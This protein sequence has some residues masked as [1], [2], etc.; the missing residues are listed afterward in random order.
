MQIAFYNA[1]GAAM[2]LLG[3]IRKLMFASGIGALIYLLSDFQNYFM[4]GNK[5][6][7]L[8]A[9]ED[10]FTE[11]LSIADKNIAIFMLKWEIMKQKM[12]P[13]GVDLSFMQGQQ[14]TEFRQD[15]IVR[16]SAKMEVYKGILNFFSSIGNPFDS[17]VQPQPKKKSDAIQKD[18][19]G[20]GVRKIDMTI[21]FNDLPQDVKNS[22]TNMDFLNFGVG[23]GKTF[24]VGGLGQNNH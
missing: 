21:N 8:G 7:I 1:G 4:F 23:F 10:F 12:L 16:D 2:F 13:N 11:W 15:G 24:N 3:A 6:G 22:A 5:D 20:D 18:M 17:P 9:W 14:G 19:N